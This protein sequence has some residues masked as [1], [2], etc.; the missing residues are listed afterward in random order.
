[1][2]AGWGERA[3]VRIRLTE[4]FKTFFLNAEMQVIWC[5]NEG[6]ILRDLKNGSS[7]RSFFGV[8]ISRLTGRLR[9][10]RI[11]GGENLGL[12]WPVL[13]IVGLAEKGS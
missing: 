7:S 6:C 5:L 12:W 8:V 4:G 2:Q 11:F 9:V 10:L 13:G 1:V 3:R